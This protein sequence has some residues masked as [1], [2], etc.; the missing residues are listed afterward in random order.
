MFDSVDRM[1][2]GIGEV[3]DPQCY[4]VMLAF[5]VVVRRS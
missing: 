2:L 4:G 5:G 3:M 1:A